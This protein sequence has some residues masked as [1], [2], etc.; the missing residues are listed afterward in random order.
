[1]N[2]DKLGSKSSNRHSKEENV[3]VD[4]FKD[5]EISSSDLS[6]VDLVEHLHEDESVENHGHM[7]SFGF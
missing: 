2:N 3:S 5:V 6:A 7:S 4:S 1:V